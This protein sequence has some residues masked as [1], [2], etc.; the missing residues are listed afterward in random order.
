MAQRAR[1]DE[2]LFV[3][4]I[5]FALLL[6]LAAYS[7]STALLSVLVAPSIIVAPV[8]AIESLLLTVLLV[9]LGAASYWPTN[10]LVMGTG[11]L[12]FAGVVS[13]VMTWWEERKER[14]ERSG[15]KKPT[16]PPKKKRTD[17]D[18][19]GN[20]VALTIGAITAAI[21]GALP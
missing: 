8:V 13:G 2:A 21:I 5:A 9:V 19:S 6:R 11:A 10:L 7:Q 4:G 20:L 18:E 15:R 1:R 16:K 14:K 17:D 12:G 3:R